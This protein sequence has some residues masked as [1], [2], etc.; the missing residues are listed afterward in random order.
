M[1]KLIDLTG[2]RFGRLLIIERIE[3]G[4]GR[5]TMYLAQCDCGKFVKVR[6]GNIRK[7]VTTSCGCYHREIASQAHKHGQARKKNSTRLYNIW[8]GM[9]TRCNSQNAMDY[10][11]YG[12]KGIGV[13]KE[14]EQD[15]QTFS[16]WAIKNGYNDTLTIDRINSEGNYEP[17]N[18]RW[19]TMKEQRRNTRQNHYITFS[20]KTQL[21]TDWSKETGIKTTTILNRLGRGWSIEKTLTTPARKIKRTLTNS[22]KNS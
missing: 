9:K 19:V 11:Y 12:A 13:C 21:L 18:C 8:C 14:W 7:G 15:F 17:L 16:D 3:N 2:Q 1:G 4:K 22:E 20:G 5:A 6:A 10:K